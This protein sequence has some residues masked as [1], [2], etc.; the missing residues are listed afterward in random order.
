MSYDRRDGLNRLEE[1]NNFVAY[2]TNMYRI[3]SL[4]IWSHYISKLLK[5]S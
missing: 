1:L 2:I 3:Y 4:S 5:F